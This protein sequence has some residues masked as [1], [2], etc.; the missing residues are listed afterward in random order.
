MAEHQLNSRNGSDLEEA[1]LE[2]EKSPKK[3]TA[4]QQIRCSQVKSSQ[5][6]YRA[7]LKTTDTD[8]S[9]LQR[10]KLWGNLIDG[11]NQTKTQDQN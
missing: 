4:S 1:G 9:A 2:T 6:I 10:L 3:K 11:Y 5:F 8:Q 7:H